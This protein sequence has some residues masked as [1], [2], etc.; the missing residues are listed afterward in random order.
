MG[1]MDCLLIDCE[2][3]VVRGP[4]CSQC[5]VSVLCGPNELCDVTPDEQRAIVSLAAAGLVPPLRMSAVRPAS[6]VG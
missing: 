4:A 2:R 5:V 6:G 1:G 3:C